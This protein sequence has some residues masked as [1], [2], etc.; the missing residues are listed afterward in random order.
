MGNLKEEYY[1][2]RQFW[3]SLETWVNGS[4]TIFILSQ[5]ILLIGYAT[6]S[7]N[8]SYR[9]HKFI[10]VVVGFLLSTFWVLIGA[11][12][13]RHYE[14]YWEKL[15][16]LER[17]LVNEV[18]QPITLLSEEKQKF[19]CYQSVNLTR[20]LLQ[21]IPAIFG[22]LWVVFFIFWIKVIK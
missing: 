9:W 1:A 10:L 20:M 12:V 6:F 21:V 13:I 4:A 8:G 14:F 18:G 2:F 5:T 22:V 17:M 11:R 19:K 7:G 3:L 15:K 16:E